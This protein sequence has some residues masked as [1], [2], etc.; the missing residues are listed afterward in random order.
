MKKIIILL[1]VFLIS[2]KDDIDNK[3]TLTKDEYKKLIGDTL[4]VKYPKTVSM[5][6]KPSNGYYA[7]DNIKVYL[8]DDNHEYQLH[9]ESH[10]EDQWT[11]YPGCEKC[12]L[13]YAKIISKLDSLLK[14]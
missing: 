2:C 8:G 5:L 1:S 9:L 12:Q 7:A 3:I 4:K 10:V 6:N 14:K 11:H 13:N